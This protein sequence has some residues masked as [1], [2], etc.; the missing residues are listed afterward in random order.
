MPEITDAQK[1]EYD[2][3]VGALNA[4]WAHPEHGLAVKKAYKA[5]NPTASVP[6]VD[7]PMLAVAPVVEEVTVLKGSLA[8]LTERLDAMQ[9]EKTNESENTKLA[10]SI[11][12]AVTKYRLTPEGRATLL[13]QMKER[14]NPDAEAIAGW[15]VGE[16]AKPAPASSS[17]FAPQSFSNG[18]ID[19]V[20]AEDMKALDRDPRAWFDKTVA[21][22]LNDPEFQALA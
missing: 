1:A 8:S 2:R 20:E 21:G 4:M 10:S 6:E 14:Q 18:G 19:D 17:A 16:I 7:S 15:M 12:K 13:E 9:I 11:D 22:M 3:A 5:I